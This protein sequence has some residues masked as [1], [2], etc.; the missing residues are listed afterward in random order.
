MTDQPSSMELA[1][2]DLTRQVQVGF[3]KVDGQLA[4]LL[5]RTEA[6]ERRA[7]QQARAIEDLQDR[8]GKV[9]REAVTRGDLD[10]RS[11]RTIALLSVVVAAVGVLS[12]AGTAII[13]AAV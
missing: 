3:A 11:G 1:I 10:R 13:Q 7:D 12:S 8:L 5:Q 2:A 4:V 6:M 9:E